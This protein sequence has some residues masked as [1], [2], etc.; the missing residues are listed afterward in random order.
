MT[1]HG[2]AGVY[3]NENAGVHQNANM[4][5]PQNGHNDP[6]ND[7]TIKT[8]NMIDVTGNENEAEDED[9]NEAGNEAENEEENE[10]KELEEAPTNNNSADAERNNAIEPDT[11]SNTMYKQLGARTQ[12]N[13]RA[14]KRKSDL[15]P[16]LRIHLTI[17]SKCSKI[18]Y[19]NAMVKTMGN[20]HLYLR[21]YTRL[22][23]TIHCGPN[24]H[25]NVMRNPLITTILTQYHV[26]K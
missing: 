25:D 1:I 13:M 16:K 17:S 8:E 23:V 12:T 21:E 26:S 11:M 20:T 19:A 24:Q 7:P 9:K 22:H 18:L 10:H 4:H 2:N 6:R 3:Q 5:S 15:P 14:T